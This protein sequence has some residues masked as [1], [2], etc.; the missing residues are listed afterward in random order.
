MLEDP[1]L[2][3]WVAKID[4]FLRSL[5]TLEGRGRSPPSCCQKCGITENTPTYRCLVCSGMGLVCSECMQ[6][7]H[8]DTPLHRIQKWNGTFFEK[9]TLKS[10]G[11]RI[12]LGHRTGERCYRPEQ[13]KGNDFVI[14]DLDAVHEVSLDFCGCGGT[15]MDHVE[16][17]LE[18]RLFPATVTQPKTAAT[19]RLLEFFEVLQYESKIS[20][21]EVFTTI[22][23]LTDNTGLLEV[24]D[25]YPGLIRMVHEWRHLKLL[26]RSGRGHDPLRP[27]SETQE[28]ECA[29][30]CPP[31]P[32]PGI[33]MAEGWENE[34]I[35][36]RYLHALNI[37][38]DANFRLKRKA[39][40]NDVADPGLSRG[41]AYFVWDFPFRAF[42]K[43]RD[44]EMEPKSTCSRHDAVNLADI[45]PG[46]GYAAS[47]VGTVECTRHNMKRPCAVG[48]LQKGE[49]YCNM[50]Y[51]LVKSL[52][53][54]ALKMFIISYD[55][56][57]QWSLNLL[58][59]IRK[60]DTTS[61][62]L[63]PDCTIRFAVP[64]FHLPAH[65]PACRNK[66]AFML[67]PGAGLGDGEAPERGWGE[68][69]PLGP[70]T[71]EM[72]PG[73]RRDTLDFNFGDYNW[74]KIIKL[75]SSLL[76]KLQTATA[77]VSEQFIT[78]AE[79]EEGIKD[80]E[81][82]IAEWMEALVAYEADPEKPNPYE[83]T[84]KHPTQHAVRREL[85]DEENGA[86]GT[87]S[88]FSLSDAVSPSG[89]IAWG[90]DLEAEQRTVKRLSDQV[91][92]HSQDRQ[93]SRTQFRSNTLVRKVETWYR[94][95]QLYIPGSALLRKRDSNVSISP[96]NLPLWL[97]SQ[98]G[99][100]V[101][102]DHRLATIEYRLRVGQAHEALGTLRRYLQL[103][104]TL[105][106]VKR[107]WLRGQGANTRG[108]KAIA[109][110][111][112]RITAARDEYRK[113]RSALVSLGSLLK[114]TDVHKSFPELLD[115]H[116]QPMTEYSDGHGQTKK[117]LSWIWRMAGAS[118]DMGTD[119]AADTVRVEWAKSRARVQRYEE[120]ILLV[121]EEM[122]RTLR[123][124]N[125][126]QADWRKRW[127]AW[128]SVE[129]SQE[130]AEGLRAYAERQA[131]ICRNLHDSFLKKWGGVDDMVAAAQAEIVNP[132]LYYT[133]V[134]L[135]AEKMTDDSELPEVVDTEN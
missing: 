65:I 11:L 60:I 68:A 113:A 29:L 106:D 35:P 47:G 123:F 105:Y 92:E 66:F 80:K 3:D 85:A 95:L 112:G 33:N 104:A 24:K 14:L 5:I 129:I 61:P 116:I 88:D 57:C 76:K 27:A 122:R 26:K 102:F 125:W 39:V 79:L 94:L 52:A 45:R 118:E 4:G 72:G 84:V 13:A 43:P 64:K 20:P 78:H 41:W 103:R 97:P 32:H 21:F 16:Q 8:L 121:K 87:G 115:I 10:L 134:G 69:N 93:L 71:R 2:H 111:Q 86:M 83:F 126:K 132:E 100:Q 81:E 56:A 120:E 1:A 46:F 63:S 114:K 22:S 73:T 90:L 62:L 101:A 19:F 70:A 131:T 9:C 48:D 67:T 96:F 107:R 17:L 49:R 50:D 77:L 7:S 82:K 44:T 128:G 109:T 127:E 119:Y 12:Q 30:I 37:G 135:S 55:I 25:R 53:K 74:R 36:T 59:R 51:F 98:I 31:C 15:S 133:R 40:S 18:R 89:L 58:D 54:S 130:Y 42:L 38:L 6:T 117:V 124:F 75:G 91:W 108:L 34:P 23:R 28:G 110:V 99:S